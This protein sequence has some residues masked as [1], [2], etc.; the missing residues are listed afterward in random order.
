M[1]LLEV[2][3]GDLSDAKIDLQSS[4]TTLRDHIK[5]AHAGC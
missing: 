1:I 2:A 5:D 3:K 4:F